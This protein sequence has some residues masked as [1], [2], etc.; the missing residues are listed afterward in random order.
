MSDSHHCFGHGWLTATASLACN[1]HIQYWGSSTNVHDLLPA[2][3]QSCSVLPT[4]LE[5][6]CR[7]GSREKKQSDFPFNQ[8]VTFDSRDRGTVK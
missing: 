2:L 7:T 6:V 4:D 1:L 3:D 5:P 8:L